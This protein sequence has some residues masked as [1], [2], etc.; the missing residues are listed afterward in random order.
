MRR[1]GPN[2]PQVF[3]D[4]S[5]VISAV[6][7]DKGGSFRLFSEA[8]NKRLIL[9]ISDFVM[10]EVF[11]VLRLKYP[12]KLSIFENLLSHTPFALV[13]EPS[14]RMIEEM[15]EFISDFSDVPILAGARK[16]KVDFLITLDKK[17]FLTKKVKENV[18]FKILT[19]REFFQNHFN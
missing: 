4:S 14:Q 13:K 17:H 11:G 15:T 12:S 3:I 5:V 9:Y 10:E 1:S 6:F 8:Q 19:P 2:L 18:K 16:A 7:S